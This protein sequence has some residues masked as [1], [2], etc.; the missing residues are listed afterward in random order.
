MPALAHDPITTKLTWA[1]EVSRIVQRRCLSCHAQG[2]AIPLSTYEEA[3]PWAKAMR[4]R[5]VSRQCPPWGAV[6]GVG[7]FQND[8]SLS[9]VEIER[10]VQW[11]EGGAPEGNP[12]YL[13]RM[14]APE[15]EDLPKLHGSFTVS[16]THPFVLARQRTIV[17]IKPQRPLSLQAK[18]PDG[19]IRQLIWLRDYH[20]LTYYLQNK[21]Q[22]PKGTV[23]QVSQGAAILSE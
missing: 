7:D 4:D 15:K 21:L 13:P 10:L 9:Q 8:P 22:L 3:R 14:R 20:G 1:Q 23:L 5:V 2:S 16:A 17:A 12:I 19:S 18:L 11:V 6:R